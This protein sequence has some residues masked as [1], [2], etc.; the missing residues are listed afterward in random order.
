MDYAEAF[1]CACGLAKDA[2]R[3]TAHGGIRAVL[4]GGMTMTSITPKQKKQILQVGANAVDAAIDQ[5]GLSKDG[6]Q[7]VIEQG[8][9]FKAAVVVAALASLT[10]LSVPPPFKNEEGPSIYGHPH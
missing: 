3:N 5:A 7:L 10:N 9:D 4:Q 1:F 6:A 8:D 2:K